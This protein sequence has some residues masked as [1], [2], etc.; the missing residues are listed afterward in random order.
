MVAGPLANTKTLS[1]HFGY[2]KTMTNY[3][4]LGKEKLNKILPGK[5]VHA[6]NKYLQ[7]CRILVTF[8][9]VKSWSL[10]YTYS[11]QKDWRH[12]LFEIL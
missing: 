5:N 9:S 12:V 4:T 2:Y 7:F 10:K 8:G 3:Y 11:A 6:A 1:G